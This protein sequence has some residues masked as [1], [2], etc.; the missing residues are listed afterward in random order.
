MGRKSKSDKAYPTASA[1]E[2][3][4]IAMINEYFLANPSQAPACYMLIQKGTLQ[5][6]TKQHEEDRIPAYSTISGVSSEVVRAVC[7][8]IHPE[9]TEPVWMKI[10]QNNKTLST[11][12]EKTKVEFK[13]F[14]YLTGEKPCDPLVCY[15]RR[16]LA[17]IYQSESE[18]RGHRPLHIEPDFKVDFAEHGCYCFTN[19]QEDNEG[20]EVWKAIKHVSGEE[21]S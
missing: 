21:A 17:E 19:L 10:M 5:S 8:A 16:L 11:S 9:L 6:K 7:T 3:H 1:G 15:S 2:K 18:K 13:I 12:G 20:N 4:A 14:Y